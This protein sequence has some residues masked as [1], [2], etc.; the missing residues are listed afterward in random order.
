MGHAIDVP[1]RQVDVVAAVAGDDNTIEVLL[2]ATKANIS[3][4]TLG[5]ELKDE[6]TQTA[7]W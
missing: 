4:K 6:N 7:I 3:P 1:A 2:V 5:E